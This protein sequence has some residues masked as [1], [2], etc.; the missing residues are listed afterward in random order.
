[1]DEEE[2]KYQYYTSYETLNVGETVNTPDGKVFTVPMSGQYQITA[3]I[4]TVNSPNN[5]PIMITRIGSYCYHNM[6]MLSYALSD[7]QQCEFC[8]ETHYVPYGSTG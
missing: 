4:Y 2:M 7:Y 8:G 5:N 6:K 3:T 1:M